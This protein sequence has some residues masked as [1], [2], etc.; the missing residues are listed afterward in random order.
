MKTVRVILKAE[1]EE[2]FERLNKLVGDE[3][4]KGIT[5]SPNQQLL[6]SIKR[7]TELLKENPQ[8]GDHIPRA[9][10]MKTGLPVANLWRIELTGYWRMLYTITGNC[11][12]IICYV[13]DIMDHRKY[14][15]L[16]RYRKK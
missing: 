9:L 5:N 13:L 16:F 11:I 2:E 14:D 12:E 6:R 7:V 10:A 1:A 4:K 15:K 3:Q 8:Y